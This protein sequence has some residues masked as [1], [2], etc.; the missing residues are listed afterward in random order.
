MITAPAWKEI[1]YTLSAETDYALA[2]GSDTLFEGHAVPSPEGSAEIDLGRLMRDSLRQPE[3]PYLASWQESGL[4]THMQSIAD[5]S[6]SD[7]SGVTLET[8]R[9]FYMYDGEVPEQDI[10]YLSTVVNGHLDPRMRL[11]CTVLSNTDSE[12]LDVR[13]IDIIPYE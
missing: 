8:Y 3:F 5:F 12:E 13:I 11:F 7:G 6:L 9:M 4:T 1:S 10:N 2:G